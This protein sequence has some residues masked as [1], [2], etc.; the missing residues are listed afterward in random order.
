MKHAFYA[1]LGGFFLCTLDFKPIPLDAKQLLYL[2][3][4]KYINYP[5]YTEKEI[6]D[7]NKMDVLIRFVSVIQILWFTVITIARAAEGLVIT[8]LELTTAAFVFCSLGAI[9]Y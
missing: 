5:V 4:C 8:G 9:F 6:D 2:I 7:K 3:N 1:N